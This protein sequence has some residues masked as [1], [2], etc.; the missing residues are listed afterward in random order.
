MSLTVIMSSA[1]ISPFDI[2]DELQERL[3]AAS[4]PD[5]TFPYTF[6]GSEIQGMVHGGADVGTKRRGYFPEVSISGTGAG[7][8]A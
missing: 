6:F 1:I 3:D 4:A 8:A 2:P 7:V 5:G